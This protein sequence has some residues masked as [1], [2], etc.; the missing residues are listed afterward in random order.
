[1][2]V[3]FILPHQSNHIHLNTWSTADITS[4]KNTLF[5]IIFSYV[6]YTK[7]KVITFFT[8]TELKKIIYTFL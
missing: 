1:M 7:T 4:S 3:K 5:P 8:D 6:V 2:E